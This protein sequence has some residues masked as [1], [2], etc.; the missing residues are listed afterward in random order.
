M[1]AVSLSLAL[2]GGAFAAPASA[3]PVGPGAREVSVVGPIVSTGTCA[4][5]GRVT[6]TARP[7]PGGVKTVV[8]A[9]GLERGSRW[10]GQLYSYSGDTGIGFLIN[11]VARG[12]SWTYVVDSLPVPARSRITLTAKSGAG[13]RCKLGVK[14][15]A[16]ASAS[17]LCE[18]PRTTAAIRVRPVAGSRR[19]MVTVPV[20]GRVGKQSVW[21]YS[22]QVARGDAIQVFATKPRRP[23]ADGTVRLAVPVLLRGDSDVRVTVTGHQGTIDGPVTTRCDLSLEGRFRTTGTTG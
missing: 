22:L 5:G 15:V 10:R 8:R 18:R 3:A 12:G 9:R 16:L 7:G 17:S 6:V 21:D 19:S 1:T 2:A 13:L 23:G 20:E 14:R 4:G 11:E